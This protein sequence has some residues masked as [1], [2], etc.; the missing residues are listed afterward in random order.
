MLRADFFEYGWLWSVVLGHDVIYSEIRKMRK[1]YQSVAVLRRRR[2]AQGWPWAERQAGRR[3]R[4]PRRA[5]CGRNQCAGSI[6]PGG[7]P[8]GLTPDDLVSESFGE[9]S[10]IG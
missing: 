7:F 2:S 10:R 5:G 4:K 1:G 3:K 8:V 6:F 9:I